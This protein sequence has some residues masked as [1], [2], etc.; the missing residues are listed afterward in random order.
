MIIA[1]KVFGLPAPD[2]LFLRTLADT[3]K[4]TYPNASIMVEPE[5][6]AQ[7]DLHAKHGGPIT[8]RLLVWTASP[9]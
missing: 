8:G 1:I 5:F 2:V 3:I 6:E 7:R 9:K 4:A